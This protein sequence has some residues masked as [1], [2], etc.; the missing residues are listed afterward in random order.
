MGRNEEEEIVMACGC[1]I[2]DTIIVFRVISSDWT[3][4]V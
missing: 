1:S 4:M 3:R 2:Y